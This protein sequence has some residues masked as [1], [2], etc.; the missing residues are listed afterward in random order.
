[1]TSTGSYKALRESVMRETQGG[2]AA[3]EKKTTTST[4]GMG[5]KRTQRGKGNEMGNMH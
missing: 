5:K 2:L 4:T 3:A 1:M